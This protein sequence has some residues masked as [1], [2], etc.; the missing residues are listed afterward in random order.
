MKFI[1][2]DKISGALFI[3]IYVVIGFFMFGVYPVRDHDITSYLVFHKLI[4]YI[5]SIM[6]IWSHLRCFFTNPGK[7]VHE[8]NPHMIEFYLNIR[9]EAQLKAISLNEKLGKKA[10]AEIPDNLDSDCDYT[11]FDDFEYPA[12]TSIQ[13]NLVD[14]LKKEHGIKFKRCDRCYVIRFPGIKHCSRC[15]GCIFGMDHHCPWIY[16]CIGQFNKKFFIQF[17][18]YSFVGLAE[19]CLISVYY[20]YIKDKEL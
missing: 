6:A 4:F 1:C 7:V 5:S 11:D 14:K 9:E 16:N 19:T 8:Y 3:I 13:D 18:G 17:L 2:R 12:V 10:F 20:V 15:Q